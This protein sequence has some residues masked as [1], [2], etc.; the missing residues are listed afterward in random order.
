MALANYRITNLFVEC[1]RGLSPLHSS[2]VCNLIPCFTRWFDSRET[3]VDVGIRESAA[4]SDEHSLPGRRLIE[5]AGYW[6]RFVF[7]HEEI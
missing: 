4:I 6:F 5:Q 1:F 7:S 2:R 3:T